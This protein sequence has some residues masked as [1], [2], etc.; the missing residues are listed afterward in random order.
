MTLPTNR[1]DSSDR[2]S[3]SGRSDRI[4]WQ[5]RFETDGLSV[6]IP[7]IEATLVEYGLEVD[8][9]ILRPRLAVPAS[10]AFVDDRP[11][12]RTGSR[13]GQQQL[14]FPTSDPAQRTLEGKPASLRILFEE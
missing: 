2:S 12:Q 14:L 6:E 1:T 9:P 13:A 4:S 7:P 8:A 11:A 3:R 10:D 5:A